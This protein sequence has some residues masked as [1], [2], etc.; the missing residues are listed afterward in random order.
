MTNLVS[1]LPHKLP[2]D[3]RLRISK[4]LENIRKISNFGEDSL[5]FS[6]PSRNK[7][8]ALAVKKYAKADVKSFLVL[9][10]FTQ[11]LYFVPNILSRI[12]YIK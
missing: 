12:V 11:F 3:L 7:T 4:K 9:S 10:D 6:L 1:E 8:L 5:L 2:I